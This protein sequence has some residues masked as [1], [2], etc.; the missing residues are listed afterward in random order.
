MGSPMDMGHRGEGGQQGGQGPVRA[1][2]QAWGALLGSHGSMAHLGH[3][4]RH[5]AT[6]AALFPWVRWQTRR[7][8]PE[9]PLTS[10]D[11]PAGV[12]RT[13]W[14]GQRSLW[15]SVGPH[16]ASEGPRRAKGARGGC[17][18]RGRGVSP[19]MGV[20]R[21]SVLG[22]EVGSQDA[23]HRGSNGQSAFSTQCAR[24]GPGQPA[25]RLAPARGQS[26]FSVMPKATKAS[27][28]VSL[29]RGPED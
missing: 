18:V 3:S 9:Q 24:A 7:P 21:G 22:E 11:L 14:C 1:D 15:E 27:P 5:G 20:G 16:W 25:D 8:H 12:T 2:F 26:S 23:T 4:R 19:E 6:E 28:S 17:R 10:A 29:A 13:G